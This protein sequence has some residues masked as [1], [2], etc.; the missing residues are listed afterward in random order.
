MVVV[1]QHRPFRAGF[2]VTD[3]LSGTTVN[4]GGT[5]ARFTES[6]CSSEHRI[7]QDFVHGVVHGKR[8]SCFG[9]VL[10]VP[11]G[12]FH[13]LS[14]KPQQDLSDA[15]ELSHLQE[16]KPQRLLDPL[17]WMFINPPAIRPDITRG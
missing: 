10:H 6:I 9:R 12:K 7:G 11:G 15:P 5:G 8:P 1:K 16:D 3:C 17:I 13:P 14:A 2:F 4:H